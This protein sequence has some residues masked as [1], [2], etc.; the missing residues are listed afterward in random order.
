MQRAA[1]SAFK[2]RVPFNLFAAIHAEAQGGMSWIRKDGG[3]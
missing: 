1:P 3:K 2:Q